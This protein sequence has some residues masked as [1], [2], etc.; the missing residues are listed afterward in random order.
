M[1]MVVLIGALC[2][3]LIWTAQRPARP[4]GFQMVQVPDRH[5]PFP[6]ALWYPTDAHPALHFVGAALMEVA[7]DAPVSGRALP[8]VVVSHGN[9]GGPTSHADLALALASAGYIVAAPMHPGDNYADHGAEGTVPWLSGR[10][11]QI[12]ATLDYLLQDWR[13]RAAIA[14]GRIGAFGFS[15]GGLTVLTAIGAQ[16]DLRQIATHCAH[17]PEFICTMF[18]QYKAP[19]LD[20]ILAQAG[21]HYSPD[22]RIRAAVLAAPG[23]AFTLGP[24]AFDNVRIPVQLWRGERDRIAPYASNSALVRSGLGDRVDFHTVAGARHYS[25]LAPCG[26]LAVPAL[27]SEEGGFDRAA[28]H[29]VMDASVLAFFNAHLPP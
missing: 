11:R 28:F 1:A 10:S 26:L 21:N 29:A 23:L 20:P 25:F 22:A 5:G 27:C 18:R 14:P 4:V 12:H 13:D 15:A 19:L 16:P 8:L 3:A 6:V 17:T 7:R 24:G 2:V 9:G